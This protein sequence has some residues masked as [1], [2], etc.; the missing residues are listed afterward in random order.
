MPHDKINIYTKNIMGFDQGQFSV[1]INY[2]DST[3][4]ENMISSFKMEFAQIQAKLKIQHIQNN[5]NEIKEID[6][7]FDTLILEFDFSGGWERKQMIEGLKFIIKGLEGK[8]D[9]ILD[10]WKE[11]SEEAEPW[12]TPEDVLPV[13]NKSV[14]L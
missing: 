11:I 14:T 13:S 12:E 4:T 2:K 6:S 8:F 9:N 7:F 3:D 1:G 5:V 10:Y